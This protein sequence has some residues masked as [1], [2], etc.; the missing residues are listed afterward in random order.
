MPD[1][2]GILRAYGPQYVRRFGRTMPPSHR[3]AIDDM[4]RCR[5]GA[6]GA[7]LYQCDHCDAEHYVYHSCRNR[8]CPK[9][10][11][12]QTL[13]WLAKRHGELLDVPYFHL[14][15]TLPHTIHS[16]VR[17]NQKALYAAL[18]GAAAGSL[19]K[20]AGDPRHLGGTIG[21]LAVLHTWGRTLTF[22]P[23]VHCLVPGGALA[24]DRRHWIQADN[25]FFLPVRALSPIFRA[26]FLERAK[27]A[28]PDIGWPNDLHRHKWVVYCVPAPRGPQA[29]LNYLGRYVHAG[30][31]PDARIRTVKNDR[32]R[33]AYT[34]T[35]TAKAKTMVLPVID[36]IARVLQHVL[37][38][39]F[40]KV[41]YYGLFAPANRHLLR[42]VQW[43]LA[44]L[45]SQALPSPN[46]PA[47][48]SPKPRPPKTDDAL[49]CPRCHIGRLRLRLILRSD[50]LR[51]P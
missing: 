8:A 4:V 32:V 22:H 49:L 48:R 24:P 29:V 31:I 26:M 10:H 27:Q 23:H 25:G 28:L 14:V 44:F 42:A 47:A 21:V 17:A 39:G 1:L 3:R 36:F 50:Q 11:G 38:R 20:L 33:F 13:D 37:P 2:A 16:L 19:T 46:R 40:H 51:P 30:P 12:A 43:L 18:M 6:L 45:P 41:R 7:H 35:R 9:C 5:T 15:F 34:D